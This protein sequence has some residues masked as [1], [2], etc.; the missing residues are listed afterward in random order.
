MADRV[1][2]GLIPSSEAGWPVAC[3][4]LKPCTGGILHI[5]ENVTSG[6]T[7]GE[8]NILKFHR[9]FDLILDNQS[10]NQLSKCLISVSTDSKAHHPVRMFGHLQM[11]QSIS[12]IKIIPILRTY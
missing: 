7:R 4:A 10:I 11:I 3:M 6:G 1:N 5:H 8:N 2:L 12:H 9:L